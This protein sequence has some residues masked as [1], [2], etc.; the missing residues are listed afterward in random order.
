MTIE[1]P[2]PATDTPPASET[3]A[4]KDKNCPFCGQAFTSSSLGRHLDLYIRAKNPKPPDGV[5]L[6]DEIKKIRGGITR[7]QKLKKEL[8]TPAKRES[9][10]S[11]PSPSPIDEDASPELN[12][13][14]LGP[15][16]DVSWAGT[17]GHTPR[18]LGTKTPEV[19]RDISR[20][21]QKADLDQRQ[22]MSEDAETAKATELALRELLRSVKEAKSVARS[23]RP[24]AQANEKAVRK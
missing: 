21:F 10:T 17:D 24:R 22:K 14:K 6:V 7:R 1:P 23:C 2:T 20:H 15:F 8:H 3:K 18:V 11:N 13:A 4:P 16:K 9:I 5:H 19:R 12:I